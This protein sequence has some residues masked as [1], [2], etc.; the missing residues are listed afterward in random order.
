MVSVPAWVW[1]FGRVVRALIVGLAFGIVLG[2]L[3]MISTN[4]VSS[5][6]LAIVLITLIFALMMARRMSKFWPGAKNL[7]G[8]D[9]V[10]VARAAR[11]GHD[12]GDPRLAPAV[13]EY[14]RVLHEAGEHVRLRRW[15]IMLFAA[16]ALGVAIA[17]SIFSP[18]GEAVV[19]WLYFAFFPVEMLLW[20]RIAARLL[21]NAERAEAW[22][23]QLLEQQST[24]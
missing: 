17:D 3:A 7:T 22:A 2:L 16:V 24:G 20:P 10:K 14:S 18:L 12:I 13:I 8:A 6:A 1:R 4:S 21:V 11:G 9:R 19:S 23:T 5:G 15:L